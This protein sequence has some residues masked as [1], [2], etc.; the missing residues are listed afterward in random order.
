MGRSGVGR[1][2]SPV[3]ALVVGIGVAAALLLPATLPWTTAA[4]PAFPRTVASYSWW[5]SPLGAGDIDRATAIYQ[6]GVGV[7]FLDVPQAIVL[8]D[9]GSTYRRL[10][11]AE[12]RSTAADQGDP[13]RSVLSPDGTFAVIGSGTRTGEV[14][15]V[16]LADGS[17]T[18]FAVGEGLDAVPQGITGDGRTVLLLAGE[19]PMSRYTDADFALS[20]TL[21]ALDLDTGSIVD[22]PS[23]GA[24][25]AGAISPDGRLVLIGDESGFSVIERATGVRTEVPLD[26]AAAVGGGAFSPSSSRFAASDGTMLHIHD[27][28]GS[29]LSRA[30]PLT[31]LEYAQTVGWRDDDTVLVQGWTD[32]G[33]NTSAFAWVDVATGEVDVFSS[34][35][36]DLT[37]AAMWVTSLAA[38]L[39]PEWT[40]TDTRD[41]RGFLPVVIAAILGSGAA[42][43]AWVCTPRRRASDEGDAG[44]ERSVAE[45]PDRE[46]A[47]V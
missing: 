24:V 3:P 19:A 31:G 14:T 7:E 42:A 17:T 44:A 15:R 5:T 22:L 18:D 45:Q 41:D 43:L 26:R 39:I 32:S 12:S 46:P 8:G 20:G 34:Y 29:S 23:R 2:R 4:A 11:I 21:L 13:A 6:N 25:H 38:D 40:V 28:T 10:T 33:A 35:R 47:P 1:S 36:P 30:W 27:V 9:D 16:T 37:G